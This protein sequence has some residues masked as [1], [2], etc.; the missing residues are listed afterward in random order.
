MMTATNYDHLTE[1]LMYSNGIKVTSLYGK[2]VAEAFF[3]L[4]FIR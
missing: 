2:L 1:D 4:S 3:G